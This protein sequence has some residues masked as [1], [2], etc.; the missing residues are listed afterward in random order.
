MTISEASMRIAISNIVHFGDTDVLPFPLERHWFTDEPD[1][2]LELLQ[3]IDK[4]FDDH[5]GSYPITFA[6]TLTGVGYN[7][8][9]AV[10]QI[11]P[12]WNAYLLASVVEIAKDLEK[13]RVSTDREIVFSYRFAPDAASGGLFDKAIGWRAFQKTSLNHASNA[14]FALTTDISDFYPRVYHHRLENA[15][16]LTT[17]NKEAVRRIMVMLFKLSEGTSYGLPIGGNAARLLAEIL[18]NR[19]D[20]LLLAASITYTRFVDDYA[21][22]ATSREDVQRSL[23]ILSDALLRNEGLT[24][25]R[26]KS[27]LAEHEDADSADESEAKRF[28]KIRWNYDPYSPTAEQDYDDLVEEVSK[29]DVL[30][31]LAREFR[32]TRVDEALVRQ[33]VRSVKYVSPALR[34]RAVTSLVDNLHT[35]YPVFPTVAILLRTLLPD[36]SPDVQNHLFE[37]LRRLLRER[38]HILMVPANAA[39]AV[40][41]LAHDRNEEVDVLFTQLYYSGSSEVVIRRDIIYAMARR[42]AHYWISDLQKRHAQLS[43]WE[44]R[45]LLAASYGLADEGKHWRKHR[46]P[47]LS[48]FD[49]VFLR[50]LGKMNNGKTWEIPV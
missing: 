20:R 28:L 38:S 33:L 32:K 21:I 10:T 11:D 7:G 37:T 23:V 24:L 43:S 19:V 30:T 14:K 47:E 27:R 9:R 46:E 2:V 29:F 13:A 50:W 16:G 12:L 22:F 40:R 34:D 1:S 39:Y 44:L 6:K 41:L 49:A 26:A 3:R 45:A 36:L 31:M 4:N 18:L 17:Q 48:E 5:L 8:F 15:L 25:Q 35:L 42:G